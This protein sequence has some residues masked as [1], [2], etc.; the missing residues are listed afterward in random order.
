[1]FAASSDINDDNFEVIFKK[2]E[3][4]ASN[5]NVTPRS[6]VSDKKKK[7]SPTSSVV[8]HTAVGAIGSS[9]MFQMVEK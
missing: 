5:K 9:T 1:M 3:F 4:L 2:I 7:R 8:S 6:K